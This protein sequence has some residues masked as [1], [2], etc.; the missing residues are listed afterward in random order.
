M[1][2]CPKCSN[3]LNSGSDQQ[4]PHCGVFF[5]KLVLTC[6]TCNHIAKGLEIKKAGICPSCA[7]EV[8]GVFQSG[9]N[10]S[11]SVQYSKQG[12]GSAGRLLARVRRPWTWK[13]KT[14]AWLA[15]IAIGILI[16]RLT[17]VYGFALL[18]MSPLLVLL[19]RTSGAKEVEQKSTTSC[20]AC[21]GLVSYGAPLCPHC[22]K[23]R[24]SPRPPTK[25]T[26]RHLA[27]ASAALGVFL[28][29]AAGSQTGTSPVREQA[30]WAVSNGAWNGSVSQVEKYLK[31]N[32]KD[33]DSFEAIE[34]GRV[35]KG[36]DFYTVSVKYRA[37]NSFGGYVIT[38]Q[39]F[40]LDANGNITG[41]MN[42]EK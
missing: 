5:Q 23:K 3:P 18:L 33:P 40:F 7:A 38:H 35:V 6:P 26:R 27:I 16:L 32:L 15:A 8:P 17:G 29:I 14:V 13:G 36:K 12:A 41:V 11:G 34:W 39:G 9:R 22:G 37:K 24:P 10:L 42:L 2:E 4:C 20:T 28:M 30:G 19:V 31:A 25:V 1:L 21:G